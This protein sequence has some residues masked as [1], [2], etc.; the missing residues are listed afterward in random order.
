MSCHENAEDVQYF[1][2]VSVRGKRGRKSIWEYSSRYWLLLIMQVLFPTSVEISGHSSNARQ[3]TVQCYLGHEHRPK[4]R[5]FTIQ[6]P[7]PRRGSR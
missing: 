5:E 4:G 7:K 3:F 2:E 1:V 6:T